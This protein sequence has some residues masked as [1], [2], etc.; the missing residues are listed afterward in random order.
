MLT[1]KD[2]NAKTAF[3]PKLASYAKEAGI[4]RKAS[5]LLLEDKKH[6]KR[7]FYPNQRSRQ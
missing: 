5:N 3:T 1:V 6:K 4:V 7:M 2:C